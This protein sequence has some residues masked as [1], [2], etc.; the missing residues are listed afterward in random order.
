[1]TNDLESHPPT[2]SAARALKANDFKLEQVSCNMVDSPV[3]ASSDKVGLRKLGCAL[4]LNMS[5]KR[6]LCVEMR[7]SAWMDRDSKCSAEDRLVRPPASMEMSRM[8]CNG[9]VQAC[10]KGYWRTC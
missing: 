3:P 8:G 4:V 6:M 10:G 1:M 5:L 9:R 2:M 7:Q